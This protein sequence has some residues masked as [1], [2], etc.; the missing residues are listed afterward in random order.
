MQF[1][2]LIA[3]VLCLMSYVVDMLGFGLVLPAAT[4]DLQMD[5]YRKGLLS[6]APFLGL[7]ISAHSWGFLADF[8][9]RRKT[10]C[11]SLSM[12][13]MFSLVAAVVPNFWVILVM[14]F[15]S[16]ISLSGA[17]SAM[18][19]YI[20]ELLTQKSRSKLMTLIGFAMGFGIMVYTGIGWLVQRFSLQ[21][22][23]VDGW[24]LYPWRI[25]M[26]LA[27]IPGLVTVF[28]YLHLPESPEFLMSMG[29]DGE[30]MDVLKG[31]HQSNGGEG[32]FPVQSLV[33][34][35]TLN[36]SKSL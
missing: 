31:I 2:A 10:I 16:G 13:V 24:T 21:W 6:S 8:I 7:T 28:I 3:S 14:R 17:S 22:E 4:C 12:S 15:C 35:T 5:N 27:L 25:Q 20:G 9:G 36:G 34:D 19:P 26:I 30:A 32:E 11:V 18:Y 33:K 1:V 23:I 29:R